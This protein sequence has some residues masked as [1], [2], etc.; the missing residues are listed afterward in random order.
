MCC[1]VLQGQT[2]SR[3]SRAAVL[4]CVA[5]HTGFVLQPFN[6]FSENAGMDAPDLFSGPGTPG[7]SDGELPPIQRFAADPSQ[8]CQPSFSNLPNE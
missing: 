1:A 8:A 3:D 7:A 4:P 5:L 2:A 6:Y